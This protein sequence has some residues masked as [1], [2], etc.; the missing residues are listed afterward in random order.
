MTYAYLTQLDHIDLQISFNQFSIQ[1]KLDLTGILMGYVIF[2]FYD[3]FCQAC[4]VLINKM[5][6][7]IIVFME[8]FQ[9]TNQPANGQIKFSKDTPLSLGKLE[10]PLLTHVTYKE[11]K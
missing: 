2:C 8:K 11:D 6:Y 1:S 5:E 10:D 7:S 9:F 3:I 4:G